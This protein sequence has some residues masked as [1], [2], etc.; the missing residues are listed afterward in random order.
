MTKRV[1]LYAFD[2]LYNIEC[3]VFLEG[4]AISVRNMLR[5]ADQMTDMASPVR[6][7]VWAIDN[8]PG[9]YASYK[10]AVKGIFVDRIAFA[11][12]VSREGI[13]LR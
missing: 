12:M 4:D 7:N 10:D 13:R 1:Y 11:D 9:L 6:L 2:E 8:R 3:C 5:F